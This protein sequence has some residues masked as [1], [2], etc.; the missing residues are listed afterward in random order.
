DAL[1]A[2]LSPPLACAAQLGVR[3]QSV[4]SRIHTVAKI[5]WPLVAIQLA[6]LAGSWAFLSEDSWLLYATAPIDLLVLPYLA[7]ARLVIAA[8]RPSLALLSALTFAVVS[9]T[10]VACAVA[11]G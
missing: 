2:G 8:V 7:A 6:V 10:W 9:I 4:S 5:L 1:P 3:S 11:L